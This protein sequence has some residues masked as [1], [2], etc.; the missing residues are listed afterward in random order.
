LRFKISISCSIYTYF[1]NTQ[2]A[3]SSLGKRLF[4]V[5]KI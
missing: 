3:N 1:K 5:P 2:T 4:K